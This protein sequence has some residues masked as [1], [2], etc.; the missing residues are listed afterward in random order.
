MFDVEWCVIMMG[1]YD[2][3]LFIWVVD[4]SGVYEFFI[5]VIV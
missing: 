3:M 2:V 4:V 5:G 1:E